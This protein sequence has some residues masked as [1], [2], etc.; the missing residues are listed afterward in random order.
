VTA[1][2]SGWGSWMSSGRRSSDWCNILVDIW[3]GLSK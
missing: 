1:S 3:L 2:V